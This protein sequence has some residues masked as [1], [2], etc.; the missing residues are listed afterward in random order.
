MNTQGYQIEQ[1]STYKYS[2]PTSS[3]NSQR[4]QRMI[5]PHFVTTVGNW[6]YKRLSFLGRYQPHT[7]QQPRNVVITNESAKLLDRWPLRQ[8]IKMSC[9]ELH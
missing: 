8:L 4:K 3:T 5:A 6:L 2:G 1:T 9:S 7:K